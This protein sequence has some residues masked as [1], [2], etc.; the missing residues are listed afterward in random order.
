MEV[1]PG[2]GD[3]A[4]AAGAEGAASVASQRGGRRS[5]QRHATTRPFGGTGGDSAIIMQELRHRVQ[6]LERQLADRE[7]DGWST[8]PSY[9]PS[10]GG[11]EEE[12]SHRSRSRR[13]SASRM[14]AEDTQEE[15]PIPRRR[16]DTVIYSRGRQI[17]RTTRR[18]EDGEGKSEKT[19]QPVIMGVTPFHRSILEVR[20]PKHFDKPTDM[21]Y[22][23]T[24]DPLEHLTAFEARMNLEGVGDEVRCRAFPVTLAGPAIRWFNGLPQGSIYSFSDVSRAFLAQFTTRIAKAKHPINLLG[25]TQRQGE[26]TRRY[27]D[28][29]NDE[30]LEIDGLTDSVASLCLTNGLLNENFRKH[31]TT[32]P[33]WT[34]H[35]IQTVAKEYIND[36]EVSRVVAANK[37]QSGYGQ[38]RQ[39]GG[40]GERAK[41]KVREEA[42]NKAPRPFPRVGKFTNYTPLTLP[43]MEVYQQIAEKGILPKPRPLKDR[44]GGNKNLYCDYHK[45]YGH[46]T[47]DCFDLKDA[48]EQ[49]IREG[50]LAAFSHLIRE[51]RRRYRDQDEEGKTRSAKRRQE[52]EDRDHGLTVINVVTAKNA[53]PK[54]RSAH[55]KDAKILAISSQPVQNTKKPPS[56]SFGPEDQWFSDAPENPPMVITA[57]VGTGLVK[58]ILVDTGADSNIMFR[59]VFDALGLKDADLTTHQHGVIGL[60][61]HFIKPDGVISLPISVG[62]IQGRR[63]AMAEFVILRDSTAY[64][65]ILGRKTIN[66]FEAIINTRL[67][68]MKFVTDDGSI[69]TIRGDLETAVACDNASLSLR[70]KSKEASGVFLADLDA[71]VEDK[72]RPEP[73]GDLEKFSIEDE[74]EKFTFVN[75]NLPHE[76]KEPLIEMIRANRDLFAWTPADMPGIDPQIISHHLA[77]K[78]EARPVA[79]RRRKMS[80][81]RAEEV[82]K[83]TA[84]LL[85][86]G[87]T[88]EVYVDDILAKTTRP[89]DLLNDLAS[90]FASLRQHGMRLNPLKCAFAMEA[91]KFLGFMITQRGVEANPEKCQ[92]ILQMK[93]PGCIKDVQRLAGRLTSLSRFL[94]ASAAKALP[95]FNLMKKGMAFEWTPACEEAFR[96]FKEILAAP[97]VLGKPRDGEPLYLY[98]AITSEALAAV[99][100]REDG[101]TQ[102]PVYFISRAL[103][104]AELRYS[105][106]EKLAL[107]LLT[108]SRRLKQYFQSHQVVVRTDQ[109]IRQVLQKPDLAGRMMTWSIELS[110]YEIRYE[111]RQAIKAQAMADFL[112]EVAGDP[113]EDIGTRWKLHVDGASNQT[114]GGAGIILESPNGVVYEQSVRFEFPISNNQAE[115]EALI[116]GLTLATEVGAK[117]LEVCSDSQVVTSQVNG[118]YQAKDPLLQKYLEKVKSLSQKFDEVT[119]QH[120]PRERNTRADLLS[121][122]AST[123]PGEGN[124]SLIQG[125]TREPAIT[126]HITT[127][128]PSWL[129]PITNYLEHGQVPGDEKDAVKLRREAA[130]YA[131][132]QGQLFRKGL[133]QPLLKCLH[134][135]QTDYVLREV[136]EG[137]CGHHIGGKALARKLIRAGYYWPSMMADSKEFV[138]K[139]IKCQQN[140]NFAKAPAN[141]LSLLTTS[142]PFAQWGIDLLGP[143]PVGPGQVKYLIVAIDYY[144][145]WIE[146]EPL[147]SIS[148]A[149]CRKFMWRQV[150]T[151]FGIPEAVISDN[152]TQ[153]ADK[154][155]TEFLNGLGIRQR[156]SSVEHPRTNGQVESANKVILSGLKKR[157]DNKKGTW[158]DE[159]ASVLWSYRTTEQSSTKETPFR[160]TYGVDAVIPVEIGEPSPRLLLKGVEETVEKDLIDEAREMAHLTET[161]LK[162]R[163]ALRYNTKVLKRDF[164][165]D[166]L[167]LR[168]NDIGLPTLG[169]GKLAANWEGPYRVKKVMGK[170]AFKL[171]RLDG[172]PPRPTTTYVPGTDHPGNPSITI[173]TTTQKAMSH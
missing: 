67:L 23:G 169:E 134:P 55:K 36:E 56:I 133:S 142:R 66:D 99:L 61:D 159:L 27:L 78:P 34:M 88:V 47:Q 35:E 62:Q 157:L 148:S 108:S 173:I 156:F 52:P 120:V 100:V 83:Q 121:K 3:R 77:V 76:L 43:I 146:A 98:L 41:E 168:R 122:L 7:R 11:E 79:Q 58:R 80:A 104:G 93:S 118:S 138:K 64:N 91:G 22:D 154:K 72:P 129:D 46:Q 95:F 45:G 149:N 119:I 74:G 165:P 17:R 65:I 24:Q 54:S 84:G 29:F 68:V 132:I 73:E 82:A 143:F 28:R 141:E 20:L 114:Y 26:P 128:S 16:N 161:A 33:V 40:D 102:Q 37:R 166:D 15:S 158:A 155:F 145:K 167:V 44:T 81:E 51:P 32:K 113:G 10:P 153:F 106:L 6:N 126:L 163:I 8:D 50:K 130:K 31:L 90:V 25:V 107:A 162:Q 39:S 123:K 147:A 85:E 69:G 38:T 164:E 14:E 137:C 125:M 111:P 2:P 116:G 18:R 42:S 63:S 94:G 5:P 140:A 150:I 144:T 60:G 124:R 97:L 21:R 152:G 110:Q 112:V 109:G 59:N 101:K 115:Y 57:R 53:A 87:K 49:A 71:R 139:C 9:T 117:R 103:Q 105:K 135:D 30:C 131:V 96:H 92:A 4:R 171:E 13:I 172:K 1:V 170:G 12:S 160:L 89:D 151:R 75:K 48:L 19:R 70:K 86:A 136:H 127:L